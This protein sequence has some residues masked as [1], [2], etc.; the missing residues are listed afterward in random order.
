MARVFSLFRVGAHNFAEDSEFHRRVIRRRR[1]SLSMFS[2]ASLRGC[3]VVRE[4]SPYATKRG[5][6]LRGFARAHPMNQRYQVIN[7][8]R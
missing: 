8:S 6:T 3:F 7:K 5:M 2:L 1:S 4:I